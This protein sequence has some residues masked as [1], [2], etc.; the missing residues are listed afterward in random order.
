M[1]Y[2]TR[3][4]FEFEPDWTEQQRKSFSYDLREVAIGFGAEYFNRLQAH[5]VQGYVFGL[6]L[7]GDEITAFDDFTAALKG[8]LSGF[9]FPASFQS[10]R[11]VGAVS[12][13]QFDI[14]DQNL[15]D[16]LVDHPDIYLY[17]TRSGLAARP[18]KILSVVLQSPGVERVTLTAALGTAVGITDT[19]CR[20]HYVRLAD[21][22]ESAKFLTEQIQR[23]EV[24]VVELP[25]EYEA[26]ETGESP[27]WLY[28]F[29][30]D[31][32]MDEHWRYTSFAANVV[33]D[34][35]LYTAFAINHRAIRSTSRLEAQLLEIEAK[36]D[37]SHPFAMMMPIP[38]SKPMRVEV[39]RTTLADPDTTELFFSGFVRVP[40]DPGD[41]VIGKAASFWSLLTSR[42]FPQRLIQ[43]EDDADIF[44]EAAGGVARWKFECPVTVDSVNNAAMPPTLTLDFNRPESLQFDNW[45]TENWFA[46]GYVTA[47]V[48][49]DYQVRTV[50]ASEVVSGQLVLTLNAPIS[51]EVGQVALVIPGY[52]GSAEQRRDKFDDFDNFGGFVGVPERNLS[53][54]AVDAIVSQGGKK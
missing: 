18:C 32:P 30:T 8:P 14:E 33:S 9:W 22:E 10:M 24:R 46:A 54:Q 48:G 34:N 20:L 27:V 2:L 13:T 16:T 3:P 12:A 37:A 29:F 38:L 49:L 1:T 19:I 39:F 5:V 4:V 50:L 51:I 23:R 53:L 25:H 41:R 17:V 21:D 36:F 28:H 11:V 52:D 47:G 15:R 42:K 43:P 35:T 44:D 45:A 7:E 6:L 40:S 26:F 31:G